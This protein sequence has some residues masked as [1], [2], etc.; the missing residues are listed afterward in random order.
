MKDLKWYLHIKIHNYVDVE[1]GQAD[2]LQ[3]NSVQKTSLNEPPLKSGVTAKP[4]DNANIWK[5]RKPFSLYRS[6]GCS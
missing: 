3:S 1:G 4:L 6:G 5:T 2:D